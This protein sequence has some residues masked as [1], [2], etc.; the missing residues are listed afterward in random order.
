MHDSESCHHRLLRKLGR[1]QSNGLLTDAQK[2]EVDAQ[3]W[4]Q[5]LES[6]GGVKKLSSSGFHGVT[7]DKR[8]NKYES[9][10]CRLTPAE[11][12]ALPERYHSNQNMNGGSYA[13]AEE[14]AV[15]TDK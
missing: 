14:A 3:S 9:R 1:R 11:H 2:A 6:L 8:T 12:E 15:A 13:S 10:V 7:L 5:L 4:D